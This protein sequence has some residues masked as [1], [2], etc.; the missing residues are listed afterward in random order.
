ME[1]FRRWSESFRRSFPGVEWRTVTL[2]WVCAR[3]EAFRR[4]FPGV[5]WRN[6]TL[7]WVCVRSEG[8]RRALSAVEWRAVLLGVGAVWKVRRFPVDPFGMGTE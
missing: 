7:E 6:V 3:S 5:E 2:E 1:R 4:D 8:F